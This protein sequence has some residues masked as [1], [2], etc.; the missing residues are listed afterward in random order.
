METR[1]TATIESH[2]F[3]FELSASRSILDQEADFDGYRSRTGAQSIVAVD[4]ITVFRDGKEVARGPLCAYAMPY[5]MGGKKIIADI[6]KLMITEESGLYPILKSAMD[7]VVAEALSPE[8][9]AIAERNKA[10]HEAEIKTLAKHDAEEIALKN[11]I[12]C[13]GRTE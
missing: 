4:R 3:R 10:E 1:A 8:M 7:Q 12:T 6:G 11:R 9:V 13:N 5:A 2:G